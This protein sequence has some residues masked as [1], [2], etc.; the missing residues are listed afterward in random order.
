MASQSD[1][2]AG[3]F[4]F[5]PFC[6]KLIVDEELKLSCENFKQLIDDFYKDRNITPVSQ[7]TATPAFPTPHVLVQFASKTYKDYKKRETDAQY[8]TRLA[9]PDGWKLL[10]TAS[11]GGKINGY[12]GAAYWH[13][14]HQQVVI[15]HRGTKPTN[16]GA[17]WA[18]IFG[19]G[20]EN[21]VPQIG[22]ASTFTHKVAEVLRE[23]NGMKGVSFHLFFTGHSLGGWLAQVTAFTTKYLKIKEN[24]FLRSIDGN[25]CYHPHTVAFDSP[26]CKDMLVEMRDT[27]DVRLDG[28]SIDLEHLDI[29]SYLSAPNLINTCKSHL[30]TVYRIFTDLSEMRWWE[31]EFVFYTKSTHSIDKIVKIFDAATG[32]VH[33]DEQ[34]Q[35][36]V[37]LVV[38]WPISA[39]FKVSKEY[40]NFFEW[41][42]HLNNYH[43]NIKD[44]TFRHLHYYPIR[45]QTKHYD[46]RVKNFRVFSED[47]QEFLQSYRWLRQWP[48][49]FKP[50]ELFAVMEDNRAQEETEKILQ[51]FEIENE[52]IRCGDGGALQAIIP[53]VKRLLRLFPGIKENTKHA[54]SSENV[55]NRVYQFE[56][57][58]YVE[59]TAANTWEFNCDN[60]RLKEFLESEEQ[61]I[62]QV[63]MSKGDEW[64]V[65]IKVHQVLQMTGCV[66]EGQYIVL[67]LERLLK[68]N[69][70][71]DLSKLIQSTA[72]PYLL[73]IACEHDQL[74]DEEKKDV[75]RTLFDTI[76]QKLNIK[77]I[78]ITPSE[79][80]IVDFLHL[81]GRRMFGIGF[82]SRDEGLDWSDLTVSSQMKLLKKQVN[83]QGSKI[84]LNELMSAETRAAKFLPFGALLGEK[85]L[86]IADPVPIANVYNEGYYIGRSFRHQ[87]A[88][89]EDIINDKSVRDPHVYLARTVKE[90]KQLCQLN[91]KS[92]VLWVEKDKSGKLLCQEWQGSLETLRR[93]I[94]TESSPKYTPDDVDKLLEQ[95]EQQR[96][97]LI[98]DS[99]G[100]GKSTVLTHLSK[101]IKQKFPA[102]WV[103]R[104][105]LNDHTDALNA[106]KQEQIDKE[107]AIEFVSEK[108]LKL[109]PDLELELFKE[110]CG[111]N[112]KVRIVIMLDGFDEV[113]PFYKETV[114][115]LLQALRQTA[116][117]QLWV[118]TR[119]H[120]RNE[121]EDRLQQLSYTQ[122]PFSEED[123][124][125]FLTKFWILQ[126]WFTEVGNKEQ[127]KSKK[128]LEIF[129]EKLIKKLSKSISDK[130]RKFT[131]IP[132]QTRMLAEA[133]DKEVKT[134]CLL[135]NCIPDIPMKL[136]LFELYGKFIEIKYNIY[137]EE[138][139]RVPL[140]NAVAI[141]QRERDLKVMREAHQLLA[142]KVLFTEEQLSHIQNN[143]ECT[144]SAEQL[145]RI[146]IVQV[147]CEGKPQFIHRTF[148]E[149]YVADCLV[150]R[151]TEGNNTS[152]QV[153]NFILK[154]MFLEED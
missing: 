132:L 135:A 39:G 136:D 93:Y 126:D 29:T 47:E 32:Q 105:D 35:L 117:E 142:L 127:E 70:L 7:L 42:K 88:I 120:L 145:A 63:Q 16:F 74:L 49:F 45:Y 94:D 91:P 141:E 143:R 154:D 107:K 101:R 96:V 121:L 151:L 26:G 92:K 4:A 76:K 20:L 119:P 97:M 114:I 19:V 13:P 9:L 77:I 55:R 34:G 8:E 124:V 152:E 78:F 138:K 22:S 12:F 71:M 122:E 113:S 41:A 72:T 128:K 109:K 150:N 27:F 80:S 28:R 95:A 43:P 30:G 52:T 106:L 81:L 54:L 139:F 44:I 36:K 87:K 56:T 89:K 137:Q 37:Q 11:N 33:K 84:P 24:V 1:Q 21:L 133:F 38:D 82:V 118:T 69:P 85:K 149:Y 111:Q 58:R 40:E 68:L 3:R 83:F 5:P 31:I 100:M 86:T 147:S 73:L 112:Q 116:V 50:K 48:E 108:L 79:G 23:V 51:S 67:K 123:Q 60:S 131:G 10:T 6:G 148:A 62:L 99:A 61:N 104:I 46:E 2:A 66:S 98:S 25:G 125:E 15:A 75:I 110:C 130:D 90:F 102:K 57:L 64:T 65:L 144:F 153:L 140:N 129:A 53:Y 18:D 146:G 17:L 115:D 14:E 59:R 103:V 134:F